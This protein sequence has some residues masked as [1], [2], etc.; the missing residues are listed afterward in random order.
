M[1]LKISFFKLLRED[2]KRRS[3]LAAI[4][5]LVYFIC[6]PVVLLMQMDS[7]MSAV[8][9]GNIELSVAADT[10]KNAMGYQNI[11]ISVI[12]LITAVA[13]A[14]SGY[15]F[16]HSRVKLDFYH[17][18]PIPRKKFF[19]VQYT[20]GITMF[21]VPYIICVILCLFIGAG[22]GLLSGDILIV[23]IKVF[24]LRI[25]QYLMMYGTVILAMV[26]TG[27]MLTAILG[28]IVFSI[29]IPGTLAIFTGVASNFMD[30]Y[31]G[32]NFIDKYAVYL[33]P[34]TVGINTQYMFNEYNSMGKWA[35]F[36][37]GVM[38]LW[39]LVMTGLAIGLY[40]VRRTEAAENSMAF[41]KTE[42]VIK[43]LMVIPM[44]LA[45]GLY[46]GVMM[47][48][49]GVFWFYAGMLFAVVI[50]SAVIE[51]IYHFNMKEIFAHKLHI[52]ISFVITV[53]VVMCC[54]FDWI[55]YDTYLP[56][57]DS[58]EQMALYSS[59]INRYGYGRSSSGEV[60]YNTRDGLEATLTEN[61]DPIYELAKEGVDGEKDRSV[62][63][64]VE[65]KLKNGKKVF[66][67]YSVNRET[68]NTAYEE[69]FKNEE[70]IEK[71]FPVFSLP[72]ADVYSIYLSGLTDSFVLDLSSTKRGELMEIY[73]SDLRKVGY[74]D[75]RNNIIG[76][77][78]FEYDMSGGQKMQYQYSDSG[79]PIS[80][81]FTNTIAFLKN[82]LNVELQET[83]D[84]KTVKSISVS[85]YGNENT[86]YLEFTDINDIEE[87][88]EYTVNDFYNNYNYDEW[89]SMDI[90]VNFKAEESEKKFFYFKKDEIPPC[91]KEA[92]K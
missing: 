53:G 2:L 15:G 19:L 6:M 32:G 54:Q 28:A 62:D 87:I 80:K 60:S 58:I 68:F 18:L 91:V 78:H 29:Y 43:I 59:D 33:S 39:I 49:K 30:T 77:L 22:N 10:F 83:I 45:V 1:T 57:K 71:T 86:E 63:I 3:W 72:A 73:K 79:Y 76:T 34:V 70:F 92:L 4:T 13:A 50:L 8:Q 20:S 61:F 21:V 23:S 81:G 89:M 48:Q 44:S 36:G 42:G 88:L 56:S 55:G 66:R 31:M 7:L 46:F 74:D 64:N 16:L 37:I 82:E 40:S 65:Y 84:S 38:I 85:D 67:R 12:V 24:I 90:I 11:M 52:L 9:R 26:M 35:W 75:L 5:A 47:S 17:S 41:S 51:F 25:L 27:K 69:L 14:I